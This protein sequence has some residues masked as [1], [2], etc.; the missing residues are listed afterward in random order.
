LPDLAYREQ[1]FRKRAVQISETVDLFF[2]NFDLMSKMKLSRDHVLTWGYM[3]D[4]LLIVD[5]DK[6]TVIEFT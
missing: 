4:V 3:R 2:I 1:D 5:L 6:L